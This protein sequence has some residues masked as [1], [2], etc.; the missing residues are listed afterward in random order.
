MNESLK[1]VAIVTT[2]FSRSLV[3]YL[4][5][6]TQAPIYRKQ[7]RQNSSGKFESEASVSACGGVPQK[8]WSEMAFEIQRKIHEFFFDRGAMD[9]ISYATEMAFKMSPNRQL[10]TI[11]NMQQHVNIVASKCK[12]NFPQII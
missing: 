4:F 9:I 10:I 8:W 1:R 3:L 5:W 2:M 7:A 11:D 12:H 6:M